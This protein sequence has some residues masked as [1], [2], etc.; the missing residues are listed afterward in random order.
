MEKNI[1][2][3]HFDYLTPRLIREEERVGDPYVVPYPCLI[4][5]LAGA[6]ASPFHHLDI[7]TSIAPKHFNLKDAVVHGNWLQCGGVFEVP[8]KGH[9]DAGL[10]LG[11][12]IK[13]RE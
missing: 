8:P 9:W 13:E 3:F 11:E 1:L 6:D 12:D 7:P 10:P 4:T 5:I 2:N